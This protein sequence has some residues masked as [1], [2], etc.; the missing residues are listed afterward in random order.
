MQAVHQPA[1]VEISIMF[2]EVSKKKSDNDIEE[3]SLL[4]KDRFSITLPSSFPYG[5]DGYFV[6]E[7]VWLLELLLSDDRKP[8]SVKKNVKVKIV[9]CFLSI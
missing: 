4:V 5:L 1:E 9:S 6:L 8:E 7:L 2:L 3:L